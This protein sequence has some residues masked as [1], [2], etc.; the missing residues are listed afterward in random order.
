MKKLII[1]GAAGEVGFNLISILYSEKKLKNKYQIIAIDK[2]SNN[3]KLLKKLFPDVEAVESDL[4]QKGEWEEYIKGAYAVIQMQAQI[5][6]PLK[7]DYLKNNIY[8]VKNLVSACEKYKIT[9]LVHVSSSVVVSVA[10]DD[11]TKTKREGEKIVIKSS[12]PYTLLRPT[13]MY[14]CFDIKHL[15]YLISFFDK[16][17]IFPMPG[18]GKY[19]R[20]PLYV[21][22]FCRIILSCVESRKLKPKN[23]IY[24][25]TGKEKIYLI[26][27]LKEFYKERKQKKLFIKIP[28]PIFRLLIKLYGAINRKTRIIPEQLTA[29]TA[30]DVFPVIKWEKIF[31]ITPTKFL[32]GAKDTVNSK[33]YKYSKE[34]TRID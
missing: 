26:D 7:E 15:N 11:Y 4:A 18:S 28:I 12:V 33:Y 3:L 21:K 8:S 31:N 34:M 16:S 1:T 14:G 9:N 5:S 19:I 25:I 30:G 10:K 27:C 2:N 29:L 20:Q 13:L 24:N 17:T 6:S 22:D 32:D 23:K